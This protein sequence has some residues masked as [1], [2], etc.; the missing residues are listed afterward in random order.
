MRQKRWAGTGIGVLR[1]D[2]DASVTKSR[3]TAPMQVWLSGFVRASSEFV[4]SGCT[5]YVW[6]PILKAILISASQGISHIWPRPST[7][8]SDAPGT[9]EYI[10][11]DTSLLKQ[12]VLFVNGR[13]TTH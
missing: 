2:V 9:P 6:P 4:S 13:M 5:G 11:L 3:C 12:M 7:D 10:T 1:C 8:S